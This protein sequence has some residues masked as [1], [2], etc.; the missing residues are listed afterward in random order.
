MGE[1]YRARD[2]RL[3]RDV[4]LKLLPPALSADPDRLRRFEREAK[5]LAALNHPN[6][7]QIYGVETMSTGERDIP[8]IA[9]ELVE[10]RTLERLIG[11]KFEVSDALP[12]A[13]QI[14]DALEAA[15]DAGIVHRDLKPANI[16]L[17][18]AWGPTPTR[19]P[20]GSR[21]PTLATA[22]VAGC[23][24]K[25]VDFGLAKAP[26]L[27]RTARRRRGS[28]GH[29]GRGDDGDV[30]GKD[31]G[32]HDPRHGG[33][34][35][36]GT[37]QGPRRRSTRGHLGL[38]RCVV[39]DVDGRA[40]VRGRDR[41]RGSGRRAEGPVADSI[42][43]RQEYRRR[44]ASSSADVSSAIR[45]CGCAISARRALRCLALRLAK[46]ARRRSSALCPTRRPP[47]AVARCSVRL[48]ALALAG[49]AAYVAWQAKPAASIPVR[50][51]DL[52]AAMAPA[53][54]FA[55]SPDGSR[56]AYIA[57]GH[58]F[59]HTL[60][61]AATADLGIVPVPT[62]GLLWSPD[63]RR[64]A[65]SAESDLRIVPAEGGPPFTVCRIPGSGR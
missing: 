36:P 44:C 47:A 9:M 35:E 27:E 41:D 46:A 40:S 17:K 38:R 34:H 24:V 22:D 62:E 25:L 53:S 50:R 28:G 26:G 15:H 16:I 20:D 11:N 8:A 2:T 13:A 5:T 64:L 19:L 49:L 52:P 59:V 61:T 6:I 55:I 12:I 23:T 10:G 14:A 30:A 60:A 42:G 65:Y 45:G 37:G 4:A 58:L 39:R 63:G 7:A 3:G 51:F 29:G 57:Q 54:I 56:I 1:V 18:G 21:S 43:C 31:R 48:A 33:L 32:R